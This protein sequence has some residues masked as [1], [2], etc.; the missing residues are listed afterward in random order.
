MKFARHSLPGQSRP[1]SAPGEPPSI[2]AFATNRG[3]RGLTWPRRLRKGAVAVARKIAGR[4]Q[5]R[6]RW[7]VRFALCTTAVAAIVVAAGLHHLYWDRTGLPDIEPLARFEFPT[8]GHVYDANGQELI[9]LA[10]QY[11]RISKYEEIPPIVSHA[12]LATEDKNFFSHGGIDYST[13]PRVLSKVRIIARLARLGRRDTT[14]SPAVFP[15]GGSTITQQLVRGYFLQRLTSTENSDQRRYGVTV[16]RALSFVIGGRTVNM[17]ARKLEEMRLSLWVEKEMQERFGSKRRAKEEILARYASFIYMGNGQYGFAAAAEYYFGRPLASFTPDDADKAALLAG[18]AKSPRYYAPNAEATERVLRRRNQTLALMARN[19][20]VS[21]DDVRRAEQRPIQAIA[22]HDDKGSQAP[23]VVETVLEELKRRHG[24]PSLEDLLQ[25][26]IQVYSTVDARVQQIVNEG[27]EHGLEV[28][29]K[30]HP[31][32][33]GLIQ[34]SVVV[35]RNR[36]ASILAETSGRQFYQERSTSYSDFNRVTNSQRQPGSAMKPLVYLAAFRQG[37]FDLATM[38]P[39][40]PISVPDGGQQSG[41]W[42]SNYDGRF[43]GMIPVREALAESRNAVAIWITEQIGI[44]SVL[45]TSRSL[46]VQTPLQR[47]ATTALGASEVNVLELANAYRAMASGIL[48]Q[49]HVIRK[50]VRDSFQVETENGPVASP[51][52]IDDDALPLIQEGL[53]GVVRIPSG[54]AHALDSRGFPIAV[55]GKT[56]TTNEFRDAL[57][58]G[59]TYGPDGI[60]V[61]VRLGFDDNRSLGSK[62]TGGRVAL[63][64]FKEIMLRVYGEKLVGPVPAFPAQM[65]RSIDQYLNRGPGETAA[66]ADASLAGTS[67]SWWLPVRASGSRAVPGI[68]QQAHVP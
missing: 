5:G 22:G 12:I 59:S 50:I 52:D 15:Q 66:V 40:E 30:R 47:Y 2:P 24:E 55:M 23:A 17:L 18:I 36:D 7:V 32:G 44:D 45:R 8:I 62:E 43:K 11:R 53:R 63:P 25:G 4:R 21:R 27:L 54:T 41:K 57:F 20:F 33:K 35:L 13:I 60:T 48:V 31:S 3:S 19:G 65:E 61:A 14:D 56:G 1:R 51:V 58:V 6:L 9:E 49:P 42:I 10:R 37:T 34:G 67:E 29:E 39:D 28:Y 38:V 46:G 16:P 64:V 26:R 68:V